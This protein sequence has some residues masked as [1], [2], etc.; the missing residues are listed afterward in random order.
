MVKIP[1]RSNA[2]A[3]P[4]FV[5]T[6]EKDGYGERRGEELHTTLFSFYL[7]IPRW[8]LVQ[9]IILVSSFHEIFFIEIVLWGEEKR[10]KNE[11]Y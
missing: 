8:C 11:V 10:R 1:H 2:G 9:I 7:W 6:S 3:S 5:T 4:E